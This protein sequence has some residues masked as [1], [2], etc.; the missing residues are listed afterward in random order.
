MMEP[1]KDCANLHLVSILKLKYFSCTDNDKRKQM[2]KLCNSSHF[3]REKNDELT[4]V[5][6][7]FNLKTNLNLN[8]CKSIFS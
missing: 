8:T 7:K 4:C 5:C 2:K 1:S 3:L 6:S